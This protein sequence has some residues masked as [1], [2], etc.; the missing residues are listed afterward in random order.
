M[1]VDVTLFARGAV[2]DVALEQA[3]EYMS[4]RV[5]LDEYTKEQGVLTR[6]EHEKDVIDY[7]SLDRYYGP[8]YERGWWP[9]IYNVIMVMRSALPTCTIHYGSDSFDYHE[10][11]EITAQ[12]L[13]VM[14]GYWLG[15]HGQDYR[16]PRKSSI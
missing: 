1:G 11:P 6:C 13:D 2:S 12:K 5:L 15:P 8:G 10:I 16:L 4:M 3:V 7:H 14:W 9:E